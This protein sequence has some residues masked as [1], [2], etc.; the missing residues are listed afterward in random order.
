[1]LKG[2]II[3]GIT[4]EVA[5][6]VKRNARM[7]SS[8]ISGTMLDGSYFNDVIGTAFDYDISKS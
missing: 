6:G 3:D 8:D 4:Y 2:L 5:C 7:V 1:M